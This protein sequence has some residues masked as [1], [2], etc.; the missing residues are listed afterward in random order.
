MQ[1]FPHQESYSS[2]FYPNGKSAEKTAWKFVRNAY[3]R[4][5]QRLHVNWGGDIEKP[6]DTVASPSPEATSYSMP[7]EA[8]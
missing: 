3:T 7:R 2:D 5:S 6:G 1:T 4:A 8:Q